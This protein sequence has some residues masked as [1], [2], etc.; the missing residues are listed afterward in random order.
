V[1]SVTRVRSEYLSNLCGS[2]GTIDLAEECDG[3]LV[4]GLSGVLCFGRQRRLSLTIQ[5]AAALVQVKIERGQHYWRH[6]VLEHLEIGRIHPRAL[7]KNGRQFQERCQVIDAEAF[8]RA[9]VGTLADPEYQGFVRV[10]GTT[11]AR[12]VERPGDTD[13]EAMADTVLGLPLRE[14]IDFIVQQEIKPVLGSFR[15]VQGV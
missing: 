14:P 10:Q 15:G 5:S 11:Q 2:H 6:G 7:P 13:G 3:D 4:V 8:G 12:R 1:R 9:R